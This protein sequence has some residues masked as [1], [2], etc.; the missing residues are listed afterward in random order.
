ME[1]K[2]IKDK[3]CNFIANLWLQMDYKQFPFDSGECD[4]G[5]LIWVA[6]WLCYYPTIMDSYKKNDLDGLSFWSW[7]DVVKK[8]SFLFM[9]FDLALPSQTISPWSLNRAYIWIELG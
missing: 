2:K 5:D 1:I 8:T 4:S 6:L 9:I 3:N 7:I